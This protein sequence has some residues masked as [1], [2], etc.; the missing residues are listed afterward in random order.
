MNSKCRC[1]WRDQSQVND[2][3]LDLPEKHIGRAVAKFA[4]A[5]VWVSV[6]NTKPRETGNRLQCRRAIW[7]PNELGIVKIDK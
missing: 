1:A 5:L 2:E 7:V 6:D 4:T 3:I